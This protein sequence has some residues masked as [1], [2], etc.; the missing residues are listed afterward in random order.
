VGVGVDG[1]AGTGD[2][3]VDDGVGTGPVEGSEQADPTV[4]PVTTMG[5][6]QSV[7]SLVIAILIDP[8]SDPVN[9]KDGRPPWW[10]RFRERFRQPKG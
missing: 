4:K 8:P 9:P 1:E 6:A 5:M 2:D 10:S 7:R 3:T